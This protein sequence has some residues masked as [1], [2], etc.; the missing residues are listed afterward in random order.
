MR[1]TPALLAV[2]MVSSA[3]ALAHQ[4]TNFEKPRSPKRGDNVVVK[5]CLRGGVLESSEMEVAD[6]G[7]P[8][9]S[10]HTFHLKGKKDLLKNLREQ[11]DGSL[12]E[13]TGVLKSELMDEAARGTRVGRT[14]IVVG[15]DSSMRGGPPVPYEALP[16]LEVKSFEGFPTSC[17]R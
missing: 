1:P 10:A 6:K 11:H 3:A 7:D 17:R 13:V 14:R 8:L 16:V 5:G 4:D 2:F 12:V 9:P 15:A